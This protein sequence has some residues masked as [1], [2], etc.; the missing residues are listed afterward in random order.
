MKLQFRITALSRE[1]AASPEPLAAIRVV[2]TF[3]GPTFVDPRFGPGLGPMANW[4]AQN[5]SAS[6]TFFVSEAD[7]SKLHIDQEFEASLPST[8]QSHAA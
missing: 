4:N 3:R 6:I 8:H 2:A 7:G 1:A 5:Q